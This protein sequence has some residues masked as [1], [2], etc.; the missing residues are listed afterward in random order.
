MKITKS[1]LKQIV[2]EE[3]NKARPLS[4]QMAREHRRRHNPAAGNLTMA[5][6]RKVVKDTKYESQADEVWR[7]N[8]DMSPEEPW[9]IWQTLASKL[10][11]DPLDSRLQEGARADTLNT[12]VSLGA[13][14]RL[15]YSALRQLLQI[16]NETGVSLSSK[17]KIALAKALM[18]S[19][20][21]GAD[22][23]SPLPESLSFTMGGNPIDP[24]RAARDTLL[25][26][27]NKLQGD[28]SAL[29]EEEAF[30]ILTEIL[31]EAIGIM[32]VA[33]FGS[34]APENMLEE[35]D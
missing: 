18:D 9:N 13:Y 10:G 20:L 31:D 4:Y 30:S 14:E 17:E 26:I 2:Q 15:G 24:P 21:F 19:K 35:D 33:G 7:Q 1:Q 28:I 25:V 8:Q 5:D 22:L 6:V 29:S 3:L 27:Q 16:M 32:H 34:P 11:L 23:S 12:A